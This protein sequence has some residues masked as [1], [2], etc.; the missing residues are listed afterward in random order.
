MADGYANTP[1]PVPTLAAFAGALLE[2]G[3]KVRSICAAALLDDGEGQRW[4]NTYLD[5]ATEDGPDVRWRL[6]PNII[7]SKE[8]EAES[9]RAS[10][11]IAALADPLTLMQVAAGQVGVEAAVAAGGG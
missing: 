5:L 2:R 10:A 7:T 6:A 4:G 8:L 1:E 9:A 3:C 11:L